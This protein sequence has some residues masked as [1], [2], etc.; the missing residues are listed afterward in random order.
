MT[1]NKILLFL[2]LAGGVAF[3]AT[4]HLKE[5]KRKVFRVSI[6]EKIND[7]DPAIAFDDYSLTA[8]SQ[9]YE[10]LYQYHYLK[11]PY[12]IIPLL[13]DGMPEF[14]NGGKTLR[15]HLKK[16]I[17][18]HP[19]PAFKGEKRTVKAQ[20]FINQFKRLAFKPL[21]SPVEWFFAGK[22][23]GFDEFQEKVGED[24]QNIL[25]ENLSG[26]KVVDDYT[27]EISFYKPEVQTLH[28]LTM[29]VVVPIPEEVI[30]YEK[31]NL[32]KVEVG[33]GPFYIDTT[34]DT[35]VVLKRFKEYR[36]A[37]YP[38]T[39]DRFA[40]INK[41]LQD[42]HKK[43]PFL[44]EII[45]DN[46]ENDEITWSKV[47]DREIDMLL[48]PQ[49]LNDK[50]SS[51][52]SFIPK[53]LDELGIKLSYGLSLS[54]KWLSFN[55][56]KSPWGTNFL[57]RKAIAHSLDLDEYTKKIT[58]NTKLVANSI[59]NP[60][61]KGYRPEKKRTYEY[62]L[63]KGKLALKEAG[64]EDGKGLPSLHYYTR[65]DRSDQ[66]DFAYF[67]KASL[68][69]VGINVITHIQSFADYLKNARSKDNQ[70]EA[71]LD[72]WIY[73]Y[74]D[75]ENIMQL[76]VSTVGPALNKTRFKNNDFD[77]T[78]RNY[79]HSGFLDERESYLLKAEDI[80]D[81]NLPWIMLSYESNMILTQKRV[82][83]FRYSSIIRN[84]FKY[85]DLENE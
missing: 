55:M 48:V 27:F 71:W 36:D 75:P 62:S 70:M 66:V 78:Y 57:L 39:G 38:T 6:A 22:L 20:D 40:N 59:F 46:F 73:D 13:A 45:I 80:I 69:K 11:R 14:L 53:E 9:A 60:G 74:P 2:L 12:E 56:K 65:G 32:S 24:W 85:V 49:S 82:K 72:G 8:T 31:N 79:V 84:S 64:Y 44:D 16:G 37:T 29:P 19:H 67:L 51:Q 34:S 18:Y 3:F 76:L 42:D 50:V 68:E 21:K 33:T 54:A 47:L 15:V 1:K 43:I 23:V 52:D 25:K 77:N 58:N 83:N 81:E 10:S 41:L 63:E 35:H 26:I 28:Y 5:K 61:I 30:I 4:S 17:L 7:I